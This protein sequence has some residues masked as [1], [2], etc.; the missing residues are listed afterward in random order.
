VLSRRL[1]LFHGESFYL[2]HQQPIDGVSFTRHQTRVHV[3]HPSGAPL[4]RPAGMELAALRLPPSFAP[5]RYQQRTSR[6]GTGHRARTWNRRNLHPRICGFRGV[7]YGDPVH[8]AR[9]APGSCDTKSD[10]GGVVLCGLLCLGPC[11]SC[12]G[13]LPAPGI[14]G[15]AGQRRIPRSRISM[16]ASA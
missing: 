3:L 9:G 7:V 12:C 2:R 6:A 14:A 5:R 16:R 1:P 11:M 15:D 8:R 13:A 10:P 4:T